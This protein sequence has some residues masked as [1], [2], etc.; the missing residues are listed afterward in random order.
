MIRNG[1]LIIL[2]IAREVLNIENTVIPND[3][4]GK[5]A[6]HFFKIYKYKSLVIARSK[7]FLKVSSS[8][9]YKNS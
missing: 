6:A 3:E 9:I 8:S 5:K 7:I 2:N 4:E 1:S